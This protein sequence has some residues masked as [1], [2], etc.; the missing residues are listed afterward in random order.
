[1]LGL[2]FTAPLGLI[3]FFQCKKEINHY[4]KNEKLLIQMLLINQYYHVEIQSIKKWKRFK[5][6]NCKTSSIYTK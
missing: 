2:W 5:F 6:T 1:M 3:S 4:K